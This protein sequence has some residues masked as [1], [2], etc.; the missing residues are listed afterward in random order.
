MSIERE[1][2]IEPR[3]V[4]MMNALA[5]TITEVMPGLSFALLVFD[6]GGEEG[7]RMIYISNAHRADMLA[8]LRELV[9]RFEGRMAEGGTA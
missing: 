6:F 3:D 5:E 4:V 8:A 2:P 1:Q 9:V 7:K